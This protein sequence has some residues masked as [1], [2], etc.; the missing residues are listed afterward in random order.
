M[1]FLLIITVSADAQ[2]K[3]H[4]MATTDTLAIIKEFM[5]LSNGYKALPLQAAIEFRRDASIVTSDLDT[6]SVTAEFYISEEGYY[7][8]IGDMEQIACDS[9]LLM[10]SDQAQ[11]ML[12]RATDISP[13]AQLQA[14]TAWQLK[15]SSLLKLA[16][17]YQGTKSVGNGT[18]TLRLKHRQLLPGTTVAREEIE[19][20]YTAGNGQPVKV[21]SATASLLPVTAT[22]YAMLEAETGW[23][24]RL[25]HPSE[26]AYYVLQVSTISYLYK[27]ITHAPMSRLPVTMKD[28]VVLNTTGTY[29][30]AAAYAAYQLNQD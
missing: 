10:V 23:K 30:P 6:G 22:D 7:T 27:K 15:D 17:N 12:L 5:S 8:R 11:Q 1:I 3:R 20:I 13:A 16:A 2:R 29:R 18:D 25:F 24:D 26:D 19:M 21:T 14:V 9:L 4:R 28:R